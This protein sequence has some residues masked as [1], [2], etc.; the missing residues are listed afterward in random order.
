VSDADQPAERAAE[1]RAENARLDQ[2]VA[3]VTD[4]NMRGETDWGPPV[5]CEVL[6]PP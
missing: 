6:G 5:G 1:R 2:L 3:G 4:E